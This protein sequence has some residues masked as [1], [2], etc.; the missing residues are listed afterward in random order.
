[1][2]PSATKTKR[3]LASENENRSSGRYRG[4][5]NAARAMAL[6]AQPLERSPDR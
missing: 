3:T 4:F 5:N 2:P 1:V 6:K